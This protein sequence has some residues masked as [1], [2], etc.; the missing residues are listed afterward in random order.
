MGKNNRKRR[1][2]KTNKKRAKQKQSL[3]KEIVSTSVNIAPS[4]F[5]LPDLMDGK[6][7][8]E[9]VEIF[10][11]IAKLNIEKLESITSD[12]SNL[13]CRSNPFILIAHIINYG[14]MVP[15]DDMQAITLPSQT[16]I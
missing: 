15:V 10:E 13:F 12:L 1:R 2:V 16:L 5:Q 4:L 11:S 7:Q 3:K 14:L 6:S 8:D 9:R